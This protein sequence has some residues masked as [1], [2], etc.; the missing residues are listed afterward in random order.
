MATFANMTDWLAHLETVHKTEIDLGL[1]RVG[2][3]KTRLQTSCT[4]GNR[5]QTTL[6]Y[7]LCGLAFIWRVRARITA[8]QNRGLAQRNP[9]S[10]KRRQ[11]RS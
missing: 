10:R 8:S 1:T 11:Q 7:R 2:E 4:H 3:M 9:P 5:P 6:K